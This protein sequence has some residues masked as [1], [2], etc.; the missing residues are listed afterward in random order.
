[1]PVPSH[2]ACLPCRLAALPPALPR[3]LQGNWNN[4]LE[5]APPPRIESDDEQAH[6]AAL[7]A[8]CMAF[9]TK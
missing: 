4:V 7:Q 2:T 6:F 5:V 3:A 9:D 1:M 8:A